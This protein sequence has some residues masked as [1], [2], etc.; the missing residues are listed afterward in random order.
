MFKHWLR[1]QY[2]RQQSGYRKLLLLAGYWPLPFDVY[3]LHF[4]TGSEVPSH[5]DPVTAGRHYRLNIV[6]KAAKKGGEFHCAAPLYQSNRIKFFR[7]DQSDHWVTKVEAGNRYL[8]SIGWLRR[9]SS[10]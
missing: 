6:L 9:G 3:L 10:H 8:L 2:G 4:P 7:P 5:R 1:W